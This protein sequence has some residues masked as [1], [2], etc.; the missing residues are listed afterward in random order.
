MNYFENQFFQY[1]IYKH[2]VWNTNNEC[3]NKSNQI[4]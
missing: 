2:V 3:K 4:D 1:W